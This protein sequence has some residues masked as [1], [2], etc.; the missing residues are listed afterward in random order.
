MV[1][2]AKQLNL[3]APTAVYPAYYKGKIALNCRETL[4]KTDSP[5]LAPAD[6]FWQSYEEN[7][8][9]KIFC[10]DLP[11]DFEKSE[12]DICTRISHFA[13]RT[14]G[15]RQLPIGSQLGTVQISSDTSK[16]TKF[17]RFPV[18]RAG[19]EK[20]SNCKLGRPP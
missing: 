8:V 2:L 11:Y 7:Q 9:Q 15:F 12:I 6:H 10:R 13:K 19:A 4:H 14:V 16:P 18:A 5:F 1:N 17:S 3:S 20:L